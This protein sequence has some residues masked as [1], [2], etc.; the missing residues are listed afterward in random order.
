MPAI[1]SRATS[2]ASLRGLTAIEVSKLNNAGIKTAQDLLKAAAMPT[3]EKKLAAATGLTATRMREAVNRADLVR[4]DGMGPATADFF[5]NVGVNSLKELAQRNPASLVAT[6]K[7]YATKHPE[8]NYTAPSAAKVREYV[9][10]A[11]E[12][13]GGSAPVVVNTP[14]TTLDAAKAPAAAALHAHID[15]VLFSNHPDGASFRD[16]VLNWR[17]DADKVA[18]KA[19]LHASVEA[20][21]TDAETYDKPAE[22][23]FAGRLADLYTEVK[24]NK[25]TGQGGNVYVEID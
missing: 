14:V 8:L 16:A 7:A 23:I 13:V 6:L 25:A 1:D 18:F 9:A 19:Q 20:F 10:K 5:E 2:L 3:A 4:L 12:A 15:N 24:V 17:S 22:F 11:K 21:F